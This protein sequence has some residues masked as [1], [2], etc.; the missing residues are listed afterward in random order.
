MS[1]ALARLFYTLGNI[2]ENILEIGRPLVFVLDA[3]RKTLRGPV[4]DSEVD[5]TAAKSIELMIKSME[6]R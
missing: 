1:G 2:L 3:I 4:W 5:G 6:L